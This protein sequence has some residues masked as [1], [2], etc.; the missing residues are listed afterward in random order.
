MDL[1]DEKESWKLEVGSSEASSCRTSNLLRGG[2]WDMTFGCNQFQLDIQSKHKN[3]VQ[4]V[5][6]CSILVRSKQMLLQLLLG[7]WS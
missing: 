6:I 1:L 3:S 4:K 5:P 7:T 2:I